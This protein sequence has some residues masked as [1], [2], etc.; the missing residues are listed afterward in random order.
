MDGIKTDIHQKKRKKIMFEMIGKYGKASVMIDELDNETISQIITFLNHPIF[1]NNIAIMPDA[2]AG[3]GAVVGFTMPITNGLIPNVVGVDINCGMLMSYFGKNLLSS[4]S[5]KDIDNKIR[6][7]IPIGEGKA[8]NKLDKTL[9]KEVVTKFFNDCNKSLIKLRQDFNNMFGK[10]YDI[11]KIKK[12]RK[13][14]EKE[15]SFK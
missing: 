1:T 4:Q 3:K 10:L 2:H 15:I 8:H 6:Q 5:L 7:N 14:L 9:L 12:K 13:R 11:K